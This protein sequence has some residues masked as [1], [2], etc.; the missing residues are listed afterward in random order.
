MNWTCEIAL[1]GAP[2]RGASLRTWLETAQG[3]IARL[4]GLECLD[5][6]TPAAATAID[7]YTHDGAGPLMMLML[8]FSTRDALVAAV[9]DDGIRAAADALAPDITAT[10]A[11]FERRFYPAGGNTVPAPLQ[12]PFSYVVRYHR[13]ADDE[14][15]FVAHYLTS[16]PATQAKLPGIRNVIC[17]LPDDEVWAGA[18]PRLRSAAYMIGNEVVFDDVVAFNGA[19]ASVVRQELRADY[20]RFPPFTGLNTHY[21][22]MRRRLM[23]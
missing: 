10:G 15:A 13:P 1:R 4:S 19:M 5:L 18:A 12:A 3:A 7:P 17:Y 11:A 16:H 8:D 22:M 20:H 2:D 23:G 14:A 6:Y 9:A 21:P